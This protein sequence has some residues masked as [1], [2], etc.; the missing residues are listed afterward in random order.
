MIAK[1]MH[2]VYQKVSIFAQEIMTSLT[3]IPLRVT[4]QL[5]PT[6]EPL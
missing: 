2:L 5:H 1:L 6:V 3:S 4:L